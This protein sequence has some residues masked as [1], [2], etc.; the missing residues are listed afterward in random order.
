MSSSKIHKCRCKPRVQLYGNTNQIFGISTA[1]QFW[2]EVVSQSCRAYFDHKTAFHFFSAA[3]GLWHLIDWINTEKAYY[4]ECD[5]LCSLRK[6]VLQDC[7]QLSIISDVINTVK[8]K[9]LDRS[10]SEMRDALTDID[11]VTFNF[12]NHGLS[13]L[14][15]EKFY[16]I[17]ETG[18]AVNLDEIVDFCSLFWAAKLK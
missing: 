8:H 7:P 9:K 17:D 13:T 1:Y 16:Y 4:P 14:H 11:A 6:A 3:M 5:C 2:N 15:H 18:N 10:I 12:S